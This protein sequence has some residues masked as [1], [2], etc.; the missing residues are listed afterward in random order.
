MS[1]MSNNSTTSICLIDFK[2]YARNKN[3]LIVEDEDLNISII[4][5]SFKQ[6]FN[7]IFSAHNGREALNIFYKEQIDIIITDVVMPIMSGS[8]LIQEI[9]KS[10]NIPIVMLSGMNDKEEFIKLLNIG[11]SKFVPKP[12]DFDVMSQILLDVLENLK[13]KELLKEENCRVCKL[14]VANNV[15]QEL[16]SKNFS[17]LKKLSAK[18]FHKLILDKYGI[19]QIATKFQNIKQKSINLETSLRE[20]VCYSNDRDL[21]VSYEKAESI[22]KDIIEEFTSINFEVSS[23]Q[24]LENLSVTF[25][26]FIKFF[27]SVQNF[28][29]L[30][31][32]QVH[33]LLDLEF[34]FYDIKDCIQQIFIDGTAENIYIYS[35]LLNADLEQIESAMFNSDTYMNE[36]E[37][38]QEGELEFL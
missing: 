19:E 18:D 34:V 13:Y 7:R 1:I 10:S 26:E 8:D 25:G 37:K 3:L 29:Y 6:Y 15:K 22:I 24:D 21:Y 27:R 5:N 12:F 11:V 31:E 2:S 38:F 9:R 23:F 28:D 4:K 16:K 14:A 35:D 20:L 17:T 36:N 33:V 30:S 32:E